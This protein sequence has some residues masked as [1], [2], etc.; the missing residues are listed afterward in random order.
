VFDQWIIT[1]G[2]RCVVALA[3]LFAAPTVEPALAEPIERAANW[4]AFGRTHTEQ[5]Y[6]PLAT[7]N[8][9]TVARLGLDWAL[10]LP[11]AVAFTSTPLAVDGVLYFSGDRAIVRAVDARSGKLLWTHDPQVWR[12]APRG[13]ASGWNVNR[14][15]TFYDGRVFVGTAD[16]RLLAL[17][18]KSGEV[19]WTARHFLAESRKAITGPPRA[20]AGKVFIGHGGAEF[21]TRGYVDA[22]D[23]NTGERLWRF[24]T[25]PG[26]PSDGFENKAM[27][28][29]AATWHGQWWKYGG[30]GTVWHAITYDAELNQVYLGV[31]NGDPWDYERRSEGKGDNLFLCSIVALRADTGEYLWHYQMNP[32]EEWDYKATAD[33]VL[34]DLTIGGKQRKVL[35]QAPTNGF[36]YVIDRTTG[37]LVSAEKYEKVTWAER[38]DL[39]TGRPIETAGIR[40][41]GTAK[42]SIFPGPWGAHTWHSMA[43]SPRTGLVY[44]PTM[45]MSGTFSALPP[46]PFREKFFTIGRMIEHATDPAESSGALL[47]WDPVAQRARWRVRYD[48]VWN[49]GTLTTGGDLVFHG[50]A[51]GDFRAFDAR[52]GKSLWHTDV[53]RGVSSAPIS[54]AIDGRQRIALLVGWGGLMAVNNPAFQ[55]HGWKYKGPGIRLLSFSLDGRASL[56]AV[57]ETRFSLRPA[58]AG[59]APIDAALAQEGYLIYHMASCAVCHGA[60]AMSNG[61][62][63]PDL[64]ESQATM[65]LASFRA[66][67]ADGALLPLGMPMFNDL[68]EREVR[69]LHEYVRQQTKLARPSEPRRPN[70]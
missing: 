27:A 42:A 49:G 67:V 5:R 18:A 3:A 53:Q 8:R 21:G 54:Y 15:I 11:D 23:A 41:R 55:K 50:T 40:A 56:P 60:D 31:G 7:I 65:S 51:D 30:G 64:R 10:D 20:A 38:I 61:A 39:T 13:M 14:G 45:Q 12:H 35:M 25:V 4:P 66:I 58:D 46:T 69:A 2:G 1:R 43:F 57:P 28:M 24:Y 62:S 22:F 32:G 48:A 59:S 70:R 34:A 29:A 19:Q 6:S 37:K 36:F 52:T 16:G 26:D 47:A 17:D 33:I 63:A 44:I 68:S 9:R